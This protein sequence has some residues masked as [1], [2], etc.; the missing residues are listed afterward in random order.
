MHRTHVFAAVTAVFLLTAAS[1]R[2]SAQTSNSDDWRLVFCEG[3]ADTAVVP[4]EIVFFLTVESTHLSIDSARREHNAKLDKLL[5]IAKQMKVK[6]DDVRMDLVDIQPESLIRGA[7][8]TDFNPRAFTGSS[9]EPKLQEYTARRY[10]VITLR[11]LDRYTDMLGQILETD[12]ELTRPPVYRVSNEEQV[13]EVLTRRAILNARSQ[14]QRSVSLLDM[15]LSDPIRIGE[16]D[17]YSAY[18]HSYS[19]YTSRY[20]SDRDSSPRRSMMTPDLVSFS[21]SVS[22]TFQ[23]LQPGEG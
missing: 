18:E 14:A 20:G 6:E 4:D 16:P 19:S 3:E 22:V 15:K 12:V 5:S 10:V 8:G 9:D 2:L 11:D 13:K 1:C 21:V 7:E 23:M 17:W